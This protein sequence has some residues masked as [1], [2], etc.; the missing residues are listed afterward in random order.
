MKI[1]P[2]KISNF[3]YARRFVRGIGQRSLVPLIMLECFVTG[4]RTLQA[5]KRGGFEEA[6]ERFTEESIGAAFWFAGVKMFNKMNDHIGKRLLNLHTTNFDAQEDGIRKPLK[7]FLHDDKSFKTQAKLDGKTGKLIKNLT[8]EQIAVFKALKIGS[9]ILLAN[10]L[11]GLVVPKINQHI[12]AVYHQKHLNDN[13]KQKPQ[14]ANPLNTSAHQVSMDKFMKS[15]ENKKVSFGMNYNTL[16]SIANKFENDATYQLL[17]TDVGIAGGRAVSSRNNHER[18]EVLFRDLTSI[19]FYMFNMPN[20]NRWLNQIEDGR[21]TRLDPVAA[22]QVTDHLDAVLKD[23]GGKL[24]VDTFAK[25]V[26]G[27]NANVGFIDKELLQ[28]FDEHKVITL[29]TFKQYLKEHKHFSAEDVSRYANL[30]E[31]MSKLQPEVEG[32]S[33]LTKNQIKDIFREGAVNMPEFL[34]NVF[35]VATQNASTHRYKYVNYEEL[36]E[37]KEDVVHY[38]SKIVDKARKNGTDITTDT[39]KKACRENF[40]KNSFNWGVGFAISALFLSTLIPKMQ[41]W[42]TKMTTGQDKFPGTADY[43]NE[44]KR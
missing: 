34:Q 37:L 19:Y 43:S 20:I 32:I 29:D 38:V 44:K 4:G 23:N 17:S 21:K 33:V 13:N 30:A 22:K 11:V 3:S 35:S 9:S 16:L 14:E 24:D 40:I 42:I 7:N 28:K 12:T 27:D 41:Y 5:Y 31:R 8:K 15:D 25:K 26:F 18:T 39:L 36:K 10:V 1:T 2:Q 6:R